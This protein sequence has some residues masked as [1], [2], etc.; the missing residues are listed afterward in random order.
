[1]TTSSDRASRARPPSPAPEP[2]EE[3][4]RTRFGVSYLYPIQR[5]VISNVLEGN[6]QIVVLPTGAGK[7]LCFQ[8]PSLLLTGPTLVLVPLLS[9]LS[10]QLRKMR[11]AGIEVGSLKGGMSAEE[12]AS[13]F[14]RMRSGET[15]LVLA[16]PEACLSESNCDALHACAVAHIVVDEAH[17]ISEWG[18][19]FRPAYREVGALVRRLEVRMVSAF[20]ATASPSVIERIKALLFDG[21]DVRVVAGNADRPGIS[22]SV[23]PVLSRSH[24]L[25]VI[26]RGAERPLLVFC[27]TRNDTEV[28]A[29]DMRRRCPDF[30]VAF[31]HAGLTREE[32]RA[33]EQWFL[34]SRDGALVATCAYG[35]GVDKPDI[36]TVVHAN[37][38]TSVEAYLQESGRAGRDGLPARALL[39]LCRDERALPGVQDDP[40]ARQRYE[41]MLGYAAG[42]GL[43]RRNGL[44]ALIGQDPVSCAGCDV[45][46]GSAV[47]H[48]DGEREILSFVM[49][50]RRRFAISR[51][52]EILC[53]APGPRAQREFDDCVPGY[54]TLDGWEPLEVE[55]AIRA[56]V[57]SGNLSVPERGPWADRLTG[58]VRMPASSRP[59]E[60][61]LDAAR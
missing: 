3:L 49:R 39:M 27:R 53:G 36:R 48:C 41:R 60:E 2:I 61:S 33:V 28:V 24:A 20:T 16:T 19:S 8:L 10:D 51:A 57:K 26:A 44:L 46:E 13:L 35:L 4:A 34:P 30:P 40:V 29:R 37:V 21:Q 38:P 18:E 25:G 59:K 43:C 31:Y 7:S 14:R 11:E 42:D 5:F 55:A 1:M 58:D 17:C 9:L 54:R 45:C 6:C 52:A 23:L 32:R 56:L 50:H 22:Y 15:R 47:T 12:K